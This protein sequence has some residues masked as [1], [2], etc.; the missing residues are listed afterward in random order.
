MPALVAGIHVLLPQ[1]EMWMAGSVGK[2][3]QSARGRLLCPAMTRNWQAGRNS[4][5]RALGGLGEFL[6]HAVALQFGKMI[7][8]QHAV[9]VIDLMLDAGGEQALGVLLMHLAVQIV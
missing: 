9:E 6:Q 5:G 1:L 4:L 3:T 2:F 7:Q 8:E